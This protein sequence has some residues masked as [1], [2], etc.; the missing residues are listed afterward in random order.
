MDSGRRQEENI[1]T[2]PQLC[3]KVRR[4]TNESLHSET[5]SGNGCLH[6]DMPNA[7]FIHMAHADPKSW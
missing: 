7:A 4:S 3:S 1:H 6:K 2:R 5:E